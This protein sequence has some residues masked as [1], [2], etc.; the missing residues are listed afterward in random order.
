LIIQRWFGNPW[1]DRAIAFLAA[2]PFL[3]VLR[4][5]LQAGHLS[6]PRV[7][8]IAQLALLILTMLIRIPP[9]RVTTN[10]LYWGVA[11]VASYYGF[12]TASLT[13]AGRPL[14]PG[15]VTDT[16]SM[17]SV[18]FDVYARLTLG[19]NIGFVPAQRR[20]VLSGPYRWV[21]HPIYSALFLAEVCVILEGFSW[22]NLALSVVFLGLFVAKT[23]MEEDFLRRDPAYEIYMEQ[24]RF[25]W[26][27]G[28]L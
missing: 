27:P 24:V 19:R 4:V 6:L 20:L 23:F 8:I 25:R 12:L 14:V 3:Y 5:D 26:I 28:L 16:V 2:I 18:A 13:G 7:A 17:I 1:V 21:R 10:P 9:V 11:F 15:I 22:T